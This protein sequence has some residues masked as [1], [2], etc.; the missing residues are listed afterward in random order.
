MSAYKTFP[1][2]TREF[3]RKG[4]SYINLMYLLRTVAPYRGSEDKENRNTHNSGDL[5]KD[6]R[7]RVNPNSIRSFEHFDF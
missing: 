5:K 3:V 1:G 6:K 2:W 7:K 4:I